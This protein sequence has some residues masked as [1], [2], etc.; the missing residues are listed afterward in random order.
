MKA[1]RT[2]AALTVAVFAALALLAGARSDGATN[3]RERRFYS[4]RAG[5]GL[6]APPGWTLSAHTGYLNILCLLVHPSG[7]R[8]SLAVDAAVTARDAAALADQSRPGLAAQG[9]EISGVAPG[10]RGGVVVDAHIARR[11][12]ALR[13]LYLVRAVEG[14]PSGRQ[15]IVLT[16]TTTPA[17]LAAAGGALDWVIARLDLETPLRTDDKHDHPDGGV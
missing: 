8:I 16:L 12:Q 5:V 3:N 2:V 1:V 14:T 10:P 7:S 4:A 9:I 13:Q 6:E 15:A 17:D 11:N